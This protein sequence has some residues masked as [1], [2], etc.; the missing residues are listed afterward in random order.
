MAFDLSSK[1]P[2]KHG[3][4]K[5]VLFNSSGDDPLKDVEYTDNLEEDCKREFSAVD[6]AYR[7]RAKAE[8]KRFDNAT[9]S[10]YWFCVCFHDRDEKDAFLKAAGVKTRL[11]GDKYVSGRDLAAALGLEF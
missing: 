4:K 9:D 2:K 1:L 11:M 10:E 3:G 5:S 6:D 7:A 8:S